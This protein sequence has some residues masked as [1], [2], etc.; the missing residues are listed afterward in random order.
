[1][2]ARTSAPPRRALV[3]WLLLG[4][5]SPAAPA[6]DPRPMRFERLTID[7]GLSQSV[8][9]CIVQDVTGFL[10]IGTQDGLNR[11]DGYGFEVYRHDAQDPR[12]LAHDWVMALANDPSGD[13]WVG[14]EGGGLARW[15]RASDGFTAYRHD[16]QDPGSLSSDRVSVLTRDRSGVLWVGTLDAGLNRFD[17]GK[18]QRFRH[19]PDEPASL[20]DDQVRAVYEDSKGVLWVGTWGGL[21][22]FDPATGSFLHTRHDPDDP[23]SLS[24][25]RVRAIL[26]D[27]A[28][29][30]WVGTHD[31]LNRRTGESGRFERYVHDP[32]IPGSLSHSWVR[33]LLQDADGRLW[34]GTDGGLNLWHEGT[35]SFASYRF[36]PGDASSLAGD[37]IVHLFQ[38]SSG[39]LWIGTL[40]GGLAKW[41][42]ETWAFAHYRGAAGDPGASN[43]VFAISEDSGGVLWVGTFGGG[44]ERLDRATG[45]HTRFTHDSRRP[46]TLSD[47]RVTALLHDRSGVLWIGTVAGGLNRL[48]GR[49]EAGAGFERFTHDPGNPASLSADAVTALYEDRQG[50]LWIGTYDGGLNRYLGDGVDGRGAFA[51]FRH[52]PADPASLGNE[53]IFSLAEDTTGR[54]WLATDGGG[55]NRFHP[56]TGAFLRLEHDADVAG[57]LSSN[58]LNAVHVDAEGR[59]WIG[60]KGS[61]LDRLVGLDEALGRASFENY[62]RAEG[63]PDETIW[64]ILSDDSGAL[65]LA[66]NRGLA[67]LDPGT[68]TF[69]SYGPS[70]G[71]QSNEFNLGAYF[72]S[73][74]GEL[75]F[76]GVNG[77]NAFFPER[78]EADRPPPAVVVTSFTRGNRPARLGR[79]IFDVEEVA[80]D[81]RDNFFAFE[82]AVLD[83]TAPERNRFRYRLEGFD[84]GWIDNGHRRWVSFTNLDPGSYVLQVEG[85]SHDGVW[86][87][88]RASVRIAVAP[89]PWRTW[90]ATSL[91][92]LALAAVAAIGV[93]VYREHRQAERDRAVAERERAIAEREREQVRERER[94][95]EERERLTEER[96]RLIAELAGKNAALE[97][98]NYT[99]SHDLKS[100]LVTIKGFLG[101]VERDVDSGDPDKVRHDLRRIASAADKMHA[102]LEAL[103]D[104]TRSEAPRAEALAAGGRRQKKDGL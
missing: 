12:S 86:S 21:D 87:P 68:G 20:S 30:L 46:G 35:R 43:N 102:V 26:E 2:L 67:R 22:R 76:G 60:T 16:P 4:L 103:P 44:L 29:N 51:R 58:E 15:L 93:Y 79:P 11:Y 54:L 33:S 41:R 50:R 31:G 66:T 63:L 14:T 101:L 75:F 91:Y 52:D 83:F 77:V 70:H 78:I 62:S 82:L 8:V 71:L 17:G 42:P 59:L 37:Q 23:A 27:R 74:G 36:D 104:P 9:N 92:A 94:L 5:A 85:A 96:E 90:W 39:V 81:H 32:E 13:L 84:D 1:M 24:D 61:G 95:I 89:P 28:G 49:S 47:D 3:A 80:L 25:D 7:N 34:A 72:K 40:G 18:F 99:V 57:S 38:D 64:G 45:R 65:W 56:V 48:G 97:R 53:R 69:K 88:Q 19:D 6:A 73:P 10:W 98:L 100:P 55:L